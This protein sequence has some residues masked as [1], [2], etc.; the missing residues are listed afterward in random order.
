MRS[1]L[2]LD[3]LRR[4]VRVDQALKISLA[5]VALGVALTATH[6]LNRSTPETVRI[7]SAATLKPVILAVD[8]QEDSLAAPVAI[9]YAR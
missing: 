1:N 9:A 6:A 5:L 2:I 3:M 7:D 4:P 8:W